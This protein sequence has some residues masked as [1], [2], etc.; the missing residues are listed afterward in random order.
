MKVKSLDH[1][2]IYAAEPEESA[3][4][5]ERHFEATRES[6]WPSAGRSSS[7]AASPADSPLRLRPGPE[8]ART[9][10]AS[11]SPTSDFASRTSI[12]RSQSCPRRGF[13]S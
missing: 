2:H 5:Y 6:S 9:A 12:L 1:I 10:M 11:V 7:W 4:F 8:T 13:A 3:R